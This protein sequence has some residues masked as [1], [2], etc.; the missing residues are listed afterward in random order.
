MLKSSERISKKNKMAPVTVLVP[1]FDEE[2]TIAQTLDSLKNQTWVPEKIIVIDDFSSDNTGKIS[3]EYEGVDVVRP[4]K[5][6]GSKAGAQSFALPSVISKYTIAI[7]ADTSLDDIAIEKMVEFMEDNPD[8]SA[9]CTFVMPKKVRTIMERGRYIE[10][11]FAFTFYKPIQDWFGKPLISSGCF[12]IYK[13]DDLK[14]AGGWSQRT[15][16]EDMDLTWTFYE[17][18]KKVRFNPENYCYPIEPDTIN[19]MGKQLTRWSHGF[20]QNLKLHWKKI[21]K[22][23][24]LREIIIAAVADVFI[25]GAV[26]FFI[27]PLVAIILGNPMLYA[28]GLGADAIFVSIPVLYKARK[29]KQVRRA[30]RS[31]P[32]FYVLRYVN[33]YYIYKAAIKEFLL[34][35]T[36]TKYEKGH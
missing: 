35:K 5:N 14:K 32:C 8:T 31:L 10:Y 12:S 24:V 28:Y 18:G 3:R 2:T 22:I 17:Q 13:T 34:K 29:L 9:S 11:M 16:A 25:G 20:F 19:M 15:M 1:A 27:G 7:D 26:A 30:L 33:G 21:K 23:P 6:T 4:P 36:L